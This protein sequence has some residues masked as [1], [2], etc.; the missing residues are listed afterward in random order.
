MAARMMGG[1]RAQPWTIDARYNAHWTQM[2]ENEFRRSPSRDRPGEDTRARMELIDEAMLALVG[3]IANGL[4]PADEAE[5]DRC[6][7]VG[8]RIA[9]KGRRVVDLLAKPPG[10][11]APDAAF[12]AERDAILREARD[13]EQGE[14]P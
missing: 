10:V 7:L 13:R 1:S 11:I 3:N 2:T 4:V 5:R 8:E 9:A 14:E 6:R 12:A